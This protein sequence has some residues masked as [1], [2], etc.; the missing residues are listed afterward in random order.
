MQVLHVCTYFDKAAF[1]KWIKA[2]RTSKRQLCMHLIIDLRLY[3][4]PLHVNLKGTLS[5]PFL[6]VVL[7]IQHEHAVMNIFVS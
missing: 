7:V 1:F 5:S 4:L 3:S 6:K 2:N